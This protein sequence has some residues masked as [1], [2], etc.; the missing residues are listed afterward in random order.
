MRGY[1]GFPVRRF[2][3]P[4]GGVTRFLSHA[5]GRVEALVKSSPPRIIGVAVK[6]YIPWRLNALR[7]LGMPFS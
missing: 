7:V 6:F 4:Y 5:C 1:T 2:S 3:Q